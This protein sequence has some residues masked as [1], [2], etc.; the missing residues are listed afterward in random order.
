MV[1]AA[2]TLALCGGEAGLPGLKQVVATLVR[3]VLERKSGS[4]AEGA[5]PVPIFDPLAAMVMVGD[6]QACQAS[7]AFLEVLTEAGAECGPTRVAAAGSR[8]IPLLQGVSA[9]TLGDR[10]AA[11]ING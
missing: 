2:K 11:V 6:F 7:E 1:P 3:E 10:F 8:K 9:K 5:M 4:H